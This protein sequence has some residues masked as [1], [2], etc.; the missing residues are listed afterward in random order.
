MKKYAKNV[1]EFRFVSVETRARKES[2]IIYTCVCV[3][4]RRSFIGLDF[5]GC[6]SRT[7]FVDTVKHDKETMTNAC[8]AQSIFAMRLQVPTTCVPALEYQTSRN[9]IYCSQF[10]IE[11]IFLRVTGAHLIEHTLSMDVRSLYF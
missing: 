7:A 1:R 6:V 10:T 9:F 8:V 3:C 11:L 5:S 4:N 2:N